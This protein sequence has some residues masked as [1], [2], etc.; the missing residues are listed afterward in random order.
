M[1]FTNYND[2]SDPESYI[3]APDVTHVTISPKMNGVAC[4]ITTEPDADEAVFTTRKGKRWLDGFFNP[5]CDTSELAKFMREYKILMIN[6]ELY[7]LN[8][9]GACALPLATLAGWVNVNSQRVSP[10]AIGRLAFYM[11]DCQFA[12]PLSYFARMSRLTGGLM[13]TLFHMPVSWDN[14]SVEN[15]HELQETH[16]RFAALHGE[17]SVIRLDPQYY[18]SDDNPSVDPRTIK[19]KRYHEEEGEILVAYEGLGKR[20][21]M[22]GSF[23]VRTPTGQTVRVGGGAGV[24]DATL[25]KWW[26]NPP[27]GKQL[28]Y[29]FDELSV[30]G[31]PLRAQIVAIRDYE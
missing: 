23:L 25:T 15:M 28:T 22:L 8:S 27:L 21:G 24:D 12:E 9:N 1:K 3:F 30:N 10:D 20:R 13:H 31:K 17:G 4:R 14:E 2:L 29:R 16:L 26:S 5:I 7:A 18:M 19:W 6:A 11:Y